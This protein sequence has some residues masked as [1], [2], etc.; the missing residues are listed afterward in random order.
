M[1]FAALYF[2]SGCFELE[3]KEDGLFEGL[4]AY[5][6]I[7]FFWGV[8]DVVLFN[9]EEVFV[10]I[11]WVEDLGIL[12]VVELELVDFNEDDFDWLCTFLG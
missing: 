5:W 2:I 11:D 1:F 4:E 12:A 8:E 7:F 6:T 3:F 9:E 10:L